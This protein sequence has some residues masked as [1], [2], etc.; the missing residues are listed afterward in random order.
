MINGIPAYPSVKCPIVHLDDV[1]EAHIQAVRR[2]TA[3]N[4]RVILASETIW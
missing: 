4:K 2:N 1:V 3:D